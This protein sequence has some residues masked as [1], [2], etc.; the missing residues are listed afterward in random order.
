VAVPLEAPPGY[1]VAIVEARPPGRVVASTALGAPGVL[2]PVSRQARALLLLGT[3][4][5]T[6]GVRAAAETEDDGGA[7]ERLEV[8]FDDV[9]DPARLHEALAALSVACRLCGE[10]VRV[11]EDE[12]L[13]GEYLR[14]QGWQ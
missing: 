7:K 4:A 2:A 3:T 13:A 6:K 12:A 1:Y 11:L 9:P 8:A 10:E 5:L 14:I